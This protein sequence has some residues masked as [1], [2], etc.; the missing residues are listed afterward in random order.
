VP[1]AWLPLSSADLEGARPLTG[2]D[3]PLVVAPGGP[4]ATP[5][6]GACLVTG[7]SDRSQDVRFRCFTL[8]EIKAGTAF[9][10]THADGTGAQLVGLVPDGYDEIELTVRQTT[11]RVP[12]IDNAAERYVRGLRPGERIRVRLKEHRPVVSVVARELP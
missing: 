9:T 3:A 5:S 2:V 8:A 6:P 11:V 7:R 12:V 1:D 10:L 4:C